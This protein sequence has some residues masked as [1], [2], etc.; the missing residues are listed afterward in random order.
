MSVYLSK[1]S[2]KFIFKCKFI[3]ILCKIHLWTPSLF[4]LFANWP[5]SN[6][7]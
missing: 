3:L 7:A 5:V 1:N 2:R 4:C 6:E